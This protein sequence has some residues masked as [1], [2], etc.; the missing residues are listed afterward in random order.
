MTLRGHLSWTRG[1]WKST[2]PWATTAVFP[3]GYISNLPSGGLWTEKGT[4]LWLDHDAQSWHMKA[5]NINLL[6][7]FFN[8]NFS[9]TD[10]GGGKLGGNSTGSKENISHTFICM[11]RK[12]N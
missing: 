2:E 5:N 3:W 11:Q 9:P 6:V 10:L 12:E 8:P 7:S 4:G 1:A